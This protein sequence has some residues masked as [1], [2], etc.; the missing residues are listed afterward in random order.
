MIHMMIRSR[1]KNKSKKDNNLIHFID[2]EMR[3]FN[4]EIYF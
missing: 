2:E 4:E 3:L 1:I